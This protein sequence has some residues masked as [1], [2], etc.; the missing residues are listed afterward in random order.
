MMQYP[1]YVVPTC[2]F[3]L[4]YE[5]DEHEAML[6]FRLG[7]QDHSIGL[8]E[9]NDVF[10]LPKDRDANVNFN[11]DAFWGELTNQPYAHYIPRVAKDSNIS[12]YSLRHLHRLMAHSLFPRKE[13]DSVVTIIELTILYCMVNN[14]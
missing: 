2:E 13:G 7:N 5:F 12:S 14:R 3:L 6:N 10:H 1:T 11:R 8:F 4:S 9:L